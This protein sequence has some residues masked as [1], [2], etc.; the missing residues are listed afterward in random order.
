MSEK[1][2]FEV[3]VAIKT[4]VGILYNMIA[5]PG[6]LSDWFCE[7]VNIDREMYT[8]F[9]DG[10]PEKARLLKQ[11]KNEFVRYKWDEDEEEN[12]YF[13][14]RIKIDAITKD[15]ALVVTDFADSE[16]DIEEDTIFWKSQIDDLKRVIGA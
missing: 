5:T 14:L 12:T 1:I 10:V 8:F 15:V 16:D 4:S 3:E 7:D 6:G 2:K 9:W 11:K 13:D